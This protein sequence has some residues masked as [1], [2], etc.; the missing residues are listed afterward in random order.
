LLD[1]Q[2]DLLDALDTRMVIPLIA[3][4]SFRGSGITTLTP[5][6]TINGE[7]LLLLTPQIAG[8]SK[9]LLTDEVADLSNFR[10]E[11]LAAINLLVL[12]F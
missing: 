12:G 9:Q 1:V 11:I 3:E 5:K 10:Y 6:V 7:H 8:V 2:N 4:L